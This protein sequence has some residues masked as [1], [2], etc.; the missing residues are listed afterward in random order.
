MVNAQGNQRLIGTVVPVGALRGEQSLG[1]GEFLDLVEFAQWC[2]KLGVG[3]I[4]LLPV[5]DTGYESSPYSAL[6]AFALH[7]LYLRIGELPDAASY[8]GDLE[9]IGRRFGPKER[10]PYNEILR[11]KMDLLKKIYAAHGAEIGDRAGPQ[12]PLGKWID[13]NPWVKGYAVYR[14][15]KEENHEKSWKEWEPHRTVTA[16]DVE[17][18]W[19]DK[20]FRGEHLFWVWLQEALDAQF[21]RAAAAVAEAGILLKGDI[22]ILMNEDSCD[23]WVHPGYF[24]RDLS[25]GAPPDM[26]SP[27][28]QN[29]GFPIY[30]WEAQA[31]DDYAWWRQRLKAAEKYYQAYRIDH[32]LG[33][34]RIWA[35][36]GADNSST[37]GRYIPAVPVTT[38]DLTA[39]GFDDARIRW[40]SRP[41]IPTGEVWDALRDIRD[42]WG[43]Q[44]T[45]LTAAAAEGVF[46]RVLE[47][48]GDEELWLFKDAIRGEKDIEAQEIHPAARSYLLRAWRNRIFLEYEK[49]LF[50][51]VWFYRDSRAYAALSGEERRGLEELLEKRR[52][53]SEEI[54]EQEGKKLLSVLISSS[55][56]LPCAE[57]LGAVPACVPR[58]LTKL[59]IL[60]LR[61]I[62]WFR[63]WDAEGQP[64][65]PLEEYPELSVCTPSVHDSSTLREWWDREVDQKHFCGFIGYPSLPKIYN[66][67][68]AKIILH[69]AAAAASRF[70]VFQIQDLLHLSPNWYAPDPGSERIN[71]PGTTNDF[72]WTY[73]LP[74]PISDLSLDEDLVK[75]VAE[76]STVKRKI[77]RGK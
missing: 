58:A 21:S 18:L 71:V 27:D 38:A 36:P 10:F 12:G 31:K 24:R 20:K 65:I 74:A 43:N 77:K 62:R 22:P 67:G 52:L 17:A 69:K 59:K 28:G 72:N 39:L 8:T 40:M 34:F 13:K 29:W 46:S 2:V 75:A 60:G 47:R 32:V 16:K 19:E 50:A 49:G 6:T 14:R 5:N 57:D 33:F 1:V 25:A 4:Q 42:E 41:H 44:N 23:V 61:V 30:D 55:S 70:R 63:D 3:L 11:A 53:A 45:A 64:Y 35:A 51:P 73:R 76:L 56:M 15:L 48:I 66:P 68:T 7:P 9:E 37:L 54:W 26:Y